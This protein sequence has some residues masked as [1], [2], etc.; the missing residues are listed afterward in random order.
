MKSMLARE[1]PAWGRC[2]RWAK[3]RAAATACAL[4]S[5][6]AIAAVPLSET[7]DDAARVAEGRAIY[8]GNR[9]FEQA[10]TLLGMP[11]PRTAGAC[12]SCHGAH[13]DGGAEGGVVV[14]A[15]TRQ[16]LV[17]AT[18]S[19]PAYADSEQVVTALTQGRASDGRSLDAPMP[20]FVL[21]TRE[22]QALTAYLRIVG[23][24]DDPVAGVDAKRIVLGTVLPLDTVAGVAIRDALLQRMDRLNAAGGL[25]GR[26]LELE[27]VDAGADAASTVA[28][29][30]RLARSGRVFALVASL[31]PAPDADLR[32]T[33]TA[34]DVAMVATLGVPTLPS[35][36]PRISWLL[37]SLAEQVRSLAS[38]MRRACPEDPSGATRVLYRRDAA[39]APATI[40]LPDALWEAVADA[41]GVR[42]ALQGP[43]T[44]RT[45]ALLPSDLVA[46]AR[47]RLSTAGRTAPAT[48]LGT[49]AA[50]SGEAAGEASDLRELVALPMPPLPSNGDDDS[51]IALW[52]LLADSALVVTAEALARSGRQVDTTRLLAALETV[53]RFETR[54][55]VS[56][57]FSRRRRHGFDVSYLRYGGFP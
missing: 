27:V 41:A 48:C 4:V 20:R 6:T 18:P 16:R 42:R 10:P 47:N 38:E 50:L 28:A 49:L 11:L 9:P 8:R 19:R 56:L 52:P 31:V 14:P 17:Q 13:G 55:G 36:D 35:N 7:P 24:D 53:H 57:D 32:R 15:I 5:F 43:R 44:A 54:P 40:E 30:D 33:L 23:T 29:V 26:S 25:F 12:A 37:P 22:Q 34:T 51:R 45:I 21:S 39:L 1:Y 46:V 3:Q 2:A